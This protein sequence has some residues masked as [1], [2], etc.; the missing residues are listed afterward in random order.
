MMYDPYSDLPDIIPSPARAPAILFEARKTIDMQ[1][2]E[3]AIRPP[4][5]DRFFHDVAIELA[6]AI[7][8]QPRFFRSMI[9]SGSPRYMTLSARAIVLTEEDWSRLMKDQYEAGV[10]AATLHPQMFVR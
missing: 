10:R 7:R 5:E 3:R 4:T 1:M 9:T 6:Q 2:L 8:R